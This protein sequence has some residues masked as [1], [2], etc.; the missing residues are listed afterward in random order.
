[1]SVIDPKEYRLPHENLSKE[2]LSRGISISFI[3][4]KLKTNPSHLSRCLC[5]TNNLTEKNRQKM[6]E[7]LETNY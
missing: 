1:M 2:L 6:N 4:R 5:G 3:A 7:L